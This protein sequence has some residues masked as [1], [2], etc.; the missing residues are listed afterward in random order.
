MRT[1][2]AFNAKL[3]ADKVEYFVK[4]IMTIILFFSYYYRADK[5]RLEKSNLIMFRIRLSQE[6]LDRVSFQIP[7]LVL[8]VYLKIF[9][10]MMS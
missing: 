1:A 4:L 7:E 9:N 5:G 3:A 2:G 10:K 6:S 8:H